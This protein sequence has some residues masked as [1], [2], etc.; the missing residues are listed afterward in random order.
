MTHGN[1]IKLEAGNL[2]SYFWFGHYQASHSEQVGLSI[3]ASVSLPMQH[4]EIGLI[5]SPQNS[6]QLALYATPFIL[7]NQTI[8][9]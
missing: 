7:L 4:N 8:M 5:S 3:L 6:S 1:I 9:S 2:S